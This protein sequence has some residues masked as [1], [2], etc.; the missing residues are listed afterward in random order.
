MKKMHYAIIFVIIVAVLV[1]AGC[2][3]MI[4]QPSES[5]NTQDSISETDEI[6]S[7]EI[8]ESPTDEEGNTLF[9]EEEMSSMQDEYSSIVD[10]LSS[11]TSGEDQNSQE[12]S[13]SGTP[14]TDAPTETTS[15]PAEESTSKEPS[16]TANEYD[17]LRSSHFYLDGKMYADGESNP[18]TLA[19]SDNLVYMQAT[20]DG[21]TMGFLISGGNT[22]LLNPAN[23]TYCEFGSIMSG[24]LSQ[25]GMMSQEEIM[26]YINE[27]GF[28][29]MDDL[30]DAD[31]TN[32]A[33]FNGTPCKVYIFNKSDGTKTRV[34]MDGSHLL[35]FEMLGANDVVDS[36]TYINTITADI[37]AL[38]PADYSKQNIISF[39]AS[40]ES[41]FGD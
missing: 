8:P 20:V 33:T 22:Y 1:F 13:S 23:K 40:L 16:Q 15:K 25:A 27:M 36:A 4:D 29:S 32:S 12:P 26:E 11:N 10:E 17:I 6:P 7:G 5:E 30:A 31:E 24:I 38:P 2:K 34:F 28:S 35:A 14:S 19:V 9:S 39:I 37:P 18:I 21:A 41:I 3:T